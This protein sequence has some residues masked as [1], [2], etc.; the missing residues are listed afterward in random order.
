[1]AAESVS[2][3]ISFFMREAP[4]RDSFNGSCIK[5]RYC[6]LLSSGSWVGMRYA[7]LFQETKRDLKTK[8]QI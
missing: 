8:L 6:Q 2:I 7:S 1:M 5:L 3:T 4:K